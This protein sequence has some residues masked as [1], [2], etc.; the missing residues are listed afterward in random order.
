MYR[1]IFDNFASATLLAPLFPDRRDLGADRPDS[2]ADAVAND[3][4]TMH[5][6]VDT[7]CFS[8]GEPDRALSPCAALIC[9]VFF[10]K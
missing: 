3:T 7:W 4:G 2:L 8:P 5:L 10:L 9:W 6:K 1:N